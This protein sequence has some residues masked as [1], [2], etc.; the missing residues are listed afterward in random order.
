MLHWID[1]DFIVDDFEQWYA[2][3]IRIEEKKNDHAISSLK[4]YNRMQILQTISVL[5]CKTII[6]RGVKGCLLLLL[7]W[8]NWAPNQVKVFVNVLN[9]VLLHCVYRND[10]DRSHCVITKI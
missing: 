4:F 1:V 6:R 8:I 7:I 3:D 5:W 9:D 2:K 10:Y